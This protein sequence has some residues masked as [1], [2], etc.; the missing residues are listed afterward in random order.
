[1]PGKTILIVE[2]DSGLREALAKVLT[3]SG[4]SV[5]AFATA[6]ECLDA[7]ATRRA[8]CC[9]FDIRLPGVSGLD[10]YRTLTAGGP[11]PPVIF[12]TAFD[13]ATKRE[14]ATRLGAKGYLVK[15]FRGKLLVEAVTAALANNAASIA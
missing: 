4:F 3:A 7:T 5:S 13:E 15:P 12:M 10:L 14:E 1:V 11:H 2:D 6:E 9:V 8:S